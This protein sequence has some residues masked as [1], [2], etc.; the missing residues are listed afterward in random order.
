VVEFAADSAL[1]DADV[2]DALRTNLSGYKLPKHIVRVDTLF[3]S[4]N[5]K[6]DYKWATST[7]RNALGID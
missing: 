3:R 5:G 2:V 1:T 6:S 7:A 4:P